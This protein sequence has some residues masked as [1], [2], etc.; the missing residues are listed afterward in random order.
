MDLTKCVHSWQDLDKTR[1]GKLNIR[2]KKNYHQRHKMAAI[3]TV[4]TSTQDD[5][6]RYE[7]V[8]WVCQAY[9]VSAW[10]TM[11]VLTILLLMWWWSPYFNFTVLLLLLL[12]LLLSSSSSSSVSPLWGIYTYIPETN[13]VPR[14]HS[15][16]AILVLLFMV[17]ISPVA[18]SSP[19][20]LYVSTFR[21]I[22]AVPNMVFSVVP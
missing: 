12:L 21:S 19:L 1:A 16:A 5:S 10:I 2:I 14:E 20:Y 8:F 6:Q 15:V 11:T 22:C 4:R 18:A 17:L 3:T 7:L 13:H 9:V